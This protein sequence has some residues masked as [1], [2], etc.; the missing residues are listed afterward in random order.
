[1]TAGSCKLAAQTNYACDAVFASK[2]S[3]YSFALAK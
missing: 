1:M 3:L 2:S